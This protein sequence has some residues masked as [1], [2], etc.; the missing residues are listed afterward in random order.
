[1]F[2]KTRTQPSVFFSK[3]IGNQNWTWFQHPISKVCCSEIK[4]MFGSKMD[5]YQPTLSSVNIISNCRCFLGHCQISWCILANQL[6]NQWNSMK[7]AA[8]MCV[9]PSEHVSHQQKTEP[10]KSLLHNFT[11]ST[12]SMLDHNG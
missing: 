6:Y 3:L 12:C 10:L 4:L 9:N 7:P 11:R 2:I 5:C 1:M 8:Q